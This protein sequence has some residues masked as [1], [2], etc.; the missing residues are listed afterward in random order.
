MY[1]PQRG[2]IYAQPKNMGNSIENGGALICIPDITGFTRFMAESDLE[3]SKKIIPPLL[4]TIV[5]SNILNMTVGEIEGDAV[6]FYRF[7]DL[8]TLNDLLN[9]CVE[10]YLKFNEQLRTLMV[11]F[12]GDFDKWTSPNR[13]SLK[14]IVHAAEITSTHIEGI[15]KLIGEDM[16]VVHKLLKNSI[17]D[18]EYI[19]LTE[20]LLAI[21]AQP[22]LEKVLSDYT[23]QKGADEYEYI[24]KV[25]YRYLL[26]PKDEV[27][28]PNNPAGS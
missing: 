5:G 23:V 22:E 21:Y 27:S 13:L 24:G 28:W 18:V 2:E 4:R 11:D 16:V 6:V 15:T 7:G 26:F 17:P 20:K 3:F 8:P 9:Q 25:N 14:I 1:F 19:L 12:K 10:F